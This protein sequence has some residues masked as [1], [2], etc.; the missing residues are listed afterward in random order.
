[1]PVADSWDRRTR[2]NVALL[3]LGQALLVSTT[4]VVVATSSLVGSALAERPSWATVPLGVQ[5]L[6]MMA[7]AMPASLLMRR[8]GR[9]TGFVIGAL[10]GLLGAGVAALAILAG[11]FLLFC[12]GSA[13]LGVYVGFG[14]FYRFAAADVADQAHRSR[15]ISLVL[16]GGVAAAFV[17]PNLARATAGLV[18]GATYAGSYAAL[19]VLGVLAVGVLSRVRVPRPPPP[20]AGEHA[21]RL[22]RVAAQPAYLVAVLCA[23]IAYGAMN[24]L[25]TSTPLAMSSFGLGFGAIALVIQG[26]VLGMFAPSFVTGRLI[27]RFGVLE[28]ML[29]GAALIAACIAVNFSGQGRGHFVAALILLGVGWN[30]LFVGATTLLTTTYRGDEM[31]RAQGLN[32]FL[33]FGTV[34][35]TATSAGALQALLGWHTLNLWVLPFVLLAGAA[36]LWL[37]ARLPAPLS[38]GA[39]GR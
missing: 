18:P 35:V 39:A 3:A 10:C 23:V 9:R 20:A 25:M 12:A 26:H 6:A 21:R 33:V 27:A 28:I 15:A 36:T 38:P 11:S 37:R 4:S 16:A 2:R 22:S 8:L 29:A 14:Q 32:D 17:G 24:V 1:V 30:F 34:A 13:L 31:A 19:V 7:T 5:F